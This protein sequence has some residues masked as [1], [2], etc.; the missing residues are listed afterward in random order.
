MQPR[1]VR[2]G[3][4]IQLDAARAVCGGL[5][6]AQDED[7]LLAGNLVYFINACANQHTFQ[8]VADLAQ[9]GTIQCH[10]NPPFKRGG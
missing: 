5:R 10:G 1:A 4:K 7:H 2:S 9:Q 3:R 8:L 6:Q